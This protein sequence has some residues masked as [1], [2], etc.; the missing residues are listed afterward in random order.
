MNRLFVPFVI[1]LLCSQLP[2]A[3]PSAGYAPLLGVWQIVTV[4]AVGP[5][6]ITHTEWLGKEPTGV[7][8]YDA[9]GMMSVQL[10]RDPRP[11]PQSPKGDKPSDA[12]KAKF[13]DG[14]YAY[15]GRYEVDEKANKVKHHIQGSLKPGEVS[16]T[17]TRTFE[18][19]GDN[20]SLST[21]EYEVNGAMWF[22]RLRWKKV[23]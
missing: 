1:T 3:P 17:Y 11:V 19:V 6:G 2:A 7:I 8:V 18:L 9:S 21:P 14:Y 15:F 16:I 4:E 12:E 20:L 22:N 5:K 23:K 10:M 13:F